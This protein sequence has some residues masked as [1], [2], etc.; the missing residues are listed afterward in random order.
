MVGPTILTY[1]NLPKSNIFEAEF[2]IFES[3]SEIFEAKRPKPNPRTRKNQKIRPKLNPRTQKSTPNP[4][5]I[6]EKSIDNPYYHMAACLLFHDKEFRKSDPLNRDVLGHLR[7]ILGSFRDRLWIVLG[8][9]WV[10]FGGP[11][12]VVSGSFWGHVRVI[13]E[14][15]GSR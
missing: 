15:R 11:F 13:T 3:K 9:F 10:H 7:V 8:S 4:P 6:Y 12:G 5:Q 2:W 1:G 14:V